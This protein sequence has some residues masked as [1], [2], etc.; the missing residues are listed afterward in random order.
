M[1]SIDPRVVERYPGIIKYA[2][3]VMNAK[4][5][6]DI[7]EVEGVLAVREYVAGDLSQ[8]RPINWDHAVKAL[9]I[10]YI[11]SCIRFE[12]FQAFVTYESDYFYIV[13]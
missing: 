13:L 10:I 5:S 2:I 8:K 4:T 11:L 3:A 12:K 7:T 9:S 1:D 6:A